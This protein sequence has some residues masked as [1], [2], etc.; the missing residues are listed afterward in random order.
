MGEK[1]LL[2]IEIKG[3]LKGVDGMS[4]DASYQLSFD[5][6]TNIV[7]TTSDIRQILDRIDQKVSPIILK[8]LEEEDE[9]F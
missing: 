4:R 5:N 9:L 2:V 1:E 6:L 7:K 3:L 8:E